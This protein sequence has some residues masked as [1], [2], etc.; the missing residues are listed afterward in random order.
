MVEV[1]A[2]GEMKSKDDEDLGQPQLSVLRANGHN[3]G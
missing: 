3:C 1:E 2:N